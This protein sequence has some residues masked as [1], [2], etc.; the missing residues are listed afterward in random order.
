MT[1]ELT[2]RV[3]KTKTVYFTLR[4]DGEF[5]AIADIDNTE[6]I[7]VT[8]T[9]CYFKTMLINTRVFGFRMKYSDIINVIYDIECESKRITG[10]DL[11]KLVEFD[12]YTDTV[13]NLI[14]L[15]TRGDENDL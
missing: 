6:L 13:Q 1:N 9:G 3:T 4:V 5:T 12:D 14:N 11:I 10:E 8:E 7:S 2:I 15:V